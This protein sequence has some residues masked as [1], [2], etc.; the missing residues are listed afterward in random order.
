MSG[1]LA[2]LGTLIPRMP[3]GQFFNAANTAG[4]RRLMIIAGGIIG[5]AGLAVGVSFT[6]KSAPELSHDARMKAVDPLPGG[7]HT[8]PEQDALAKQANDSQVQAAM[9]RGVSYTP[10]LSPSQLINPPPLHVEQAVPPPQ[11]RHEPVAIAR[12]PYNPLPEPLRVAF[13]APLPPPAAPPV[14]EPVRPIPVA[15]PSQGDAAAQQAAQQAYNQQIRELFAQWGGRAP[16]TDVV[17]PP[18][19]HDSDATDAS[20]VQRT[21]STSART[22]DASLPLPVSTRSDQGHLLVPAGR[23]IYA[24]PILAVNSDASSPVVLQADTGPIAGDRMIGTFAKQND[25]LVIHISSVIH[26]GENLGV[27][28]LVIAPDTMEA[29]VASDVDQHYLTRFALPAAAAFVAGLGQAIA[30][31]SNSVSVLS[32]LGGATT[33]TNLN[34]RQQ[35]GIAAGTAAA[36]A[37]A[38]LNQAAP[39]GPTVS[40][41]ANVAVGVMFLSN[42]TSHAAQ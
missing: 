24:H 8:T 5:V 9:Q 25:R 3:S 7:L 18:P 1:A 27:D 26:D 38:T 15:A 10:P 2:K 14:S 22:R 40:L 12:P 34:I 36:Q 37:G 20:P 29:G 33:A 16:R 13:P 19:E 21:P 6:G 42:V 28:G 41:E 11:V 32:P 30:T 17:M 35:L 39:K 31:T 23:G 4:P